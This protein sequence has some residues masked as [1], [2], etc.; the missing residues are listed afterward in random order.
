MRSGLVRFKCATAL[1]AHTLAGTGYHDSD[2]RYGF[3]KAPG[4][5]SE[6]SNLS[7]A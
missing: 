7:H 4:K 6:Q 1:N 3:G 5:I 2:L